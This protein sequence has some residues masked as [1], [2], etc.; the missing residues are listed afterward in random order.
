MLEDNSKILVAIQCLVYNHEP[1][2]HEC[3]DGFVMQKTNFSFVAIVHDDKSTDN[4]AGIIRE[5]SEKYP[6]IIKPIYETKNQYSKHDGSISRIMKNALDSTGAK[7][8]ALCEGDDYWTDPFKLQKQVDF[9]ESHPEVGLSYTDYSQQWGKGNIEHSMFE[10]QHQYRPETYEQHLLKPG[11]L[12]PMTWLYRADLLCYFNQSTVFSDGTYSYMLEAMRNS[13]VAYLPIV[14]ATYRSLEGSASNPI[15]PV[16]LFEYFNGTFKTRRY[17]AEKYPCSKELQQ[18]ILMR[19]YLSILPVAVM[20]G[21][22]AFI[23]EARQYMSKHD[24][25]IDLIIRELKQGEKCKHSKAYR[26]GKAILKPFIRIKE[27]MS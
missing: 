1:Y 4:S 17:Y 10:Q 16:K 8:I 7:Y 15:G 23:K 25:D 20:A 22:E 11:Y 5:Y 13:Q 26:I 18:K 12:A 9:M 14:T 2:L 21:N 24:I 3:L 6:N 19:G 27:I